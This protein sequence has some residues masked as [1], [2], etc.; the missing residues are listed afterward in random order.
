MQAVLD[1]EVIEFK[2]ARVGPAADDSLE[3]NPT[4]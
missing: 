4:S 3:W 1:E 2:R